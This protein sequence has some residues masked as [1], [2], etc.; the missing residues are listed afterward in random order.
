MAPHHAAGVRVPAVGEQ[1]AATGFVLDEIKGGLPQDATAAVWAET[2]EQLERF[3]T[4]LP[5]LLAS[6]RLPAP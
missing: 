2:F 5:G 4:H 1:F 6:L 3:E